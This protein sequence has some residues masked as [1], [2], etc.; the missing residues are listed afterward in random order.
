MHWEYC[1][2]TIMAFLV[3]MALALYFHNRSSLGFLICA[4]LGLSVSGGILQIT[5]PEV[6]V[7]DGFTLALAIFAGTMAVDYFFSPDR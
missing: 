2:G 7:F 6:E 1:L 3:G 5:K 4:G